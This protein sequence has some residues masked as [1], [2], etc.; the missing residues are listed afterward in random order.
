MSRATTPGMMTPIEQVLRENRLNVLNNLEVG[1]I[2]Y[3]L[4]KYHT[5]LMRKEIMEGF[6]KDMEMQYG[7]GNS[8]IILTTTKILHER[9]RIKIKNLIEKAVHDTIEKE[10]QQYLKLMDQTMKMF[11]IREDEL[12]KQVNDLTIKLSSARAELEKITATQ[13]QIQNLENLNW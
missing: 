13:E 9:T 10:K 4:H 5:L 11:G 7:K 12:V 1:E 2:G 3:I 8:P 6:E